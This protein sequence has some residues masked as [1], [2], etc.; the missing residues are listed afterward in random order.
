MVPSR[1]GTT[2]LRLRSKQPVGDEAGEH[3]LEE[4]GQDQRAGHEV[5]HDTRNCCTRTAG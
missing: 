4:A 2:T 3:Q 5:V 1:L